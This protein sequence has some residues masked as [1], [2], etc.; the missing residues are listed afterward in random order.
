[1]EAFHLPRVRRVALCRCKHNI[2]PGHSPTSRSSDLKRSAAGHN[3]SDGV[4]SCS[5]GQ[6]N[7]FAH[8][9]GMHIERPP[10]CHVSSYGRHVFRARAS[11]G[12]TIPL[13]GE[14][15]FAEDV[16]RVPNHLAKRRIEI[17]HPCVVIGETQEWGDD[18]TRDTFMP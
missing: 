6:V 17:H 16:V 11:P 1:M 8:S 9:V 13:R 4:L 5:H 14:I 12:W 18:R 10:G 3:F 2:L 7:P 15:A